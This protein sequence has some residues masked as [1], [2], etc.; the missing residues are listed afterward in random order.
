MT[1]LERVQPRASALQYKPKR[2]IH[3]QLHQLIDELRTDY[4]ETA[5][6][7][8]GSFSYYLGYLKRVGFQEAYRIRAEV[9]QSKTNT[10]KKLFWWRVGQL[11]KEK[12]KFSS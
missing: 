8:V 7:G 1:E 5:K 12:K 2:G 11:L 6:K 3:S 10:P 9:R 4:H